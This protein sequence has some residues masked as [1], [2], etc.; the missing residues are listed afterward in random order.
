MRAYIHVGI[1][2]LYIVVYSDL[3]IISPPAPFVRGV[4]RKIAH[5]HLIRLYAYTYTHDFKIVEAVVNWFQ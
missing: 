2:R 5:V 4:P 3:R 1:G